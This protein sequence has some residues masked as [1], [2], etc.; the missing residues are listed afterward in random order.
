[1]L[2]FNR[3]YVSNL[4][5]YGLLV[6]VLWPGT[7]LVVSC[8]RSYW[9]ALIFIWCIICYQCLPIYHMSLAFLSYDRHIVLGWRCTYCACPFQISV[10]RL[11]SYWFWFHRYICLMDSHYHFYTW[12]AV[13]VL[14]WVSDSSCGIQ[15]S[16]QWSCH[17]FTCIVDDLSP[18]FSYIHRSVLF[19]CQICVPL[20]PHILL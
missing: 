14:V 13:V 7:S 2:Q 15:L 8:R 11:H 19:R 5:P 6:W 16:F 17:I 18:F 9:W 4:L 3:H 20:G 12:M 10:S 1:M